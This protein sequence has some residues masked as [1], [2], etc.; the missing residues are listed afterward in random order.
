MENHPREAGI[1]A[2]LKERTEMERVRRPQIDICIPKTR[3]KLEGHS[4]AVSNL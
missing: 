3:M 2:A 1:L 4:L